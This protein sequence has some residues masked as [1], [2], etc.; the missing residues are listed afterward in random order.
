MRWSGMLRLAKG[1]ARLAPSVAH[2]KA[3]PAALRPRDSTRAAMP[4]ELELPLRDL[5]LLV[6]LRPLLPR[7]LVRDFPLLSDWLLLRL[8]VERRAAAVLV[9]FA[10]PP[11]EDC[12]F[13]PD[14]RGPL[15][16]PPSCWP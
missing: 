3:L 6:L 14:F 10:A 5:R 9:R 2:S 13:R 1:M 7:V 12:F 8:A 11:R 15:L 4:L 16:R